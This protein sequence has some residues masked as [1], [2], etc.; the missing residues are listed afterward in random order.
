MKKKNVISAILVLALLFSLAPSAVAASGYKAETSAQNTANNNYTGAILTYNDYDNRGTMSPSGDVDWWKISFNA[1]GTANFWIGDILYP[2]DFDLYVYASNGTTLLGSSTTRGSADETVTFAVT[3]GTVYYCK[4]VTYPSTGTYT[5]TPYL[6]RAKVYPNLAVPLIGQEADWTCGAANMRMVLAY[7]GVSATEAAVISKAAAI[8]G[9][10]NGCQYQ[11]RLYEVLN[12]YPTGVTYKYTHF[13][14]ST[15][16]NYNE[17]IYKN[18]SNGKPV[19]ALIAYNYNI[20][21]CGNLHF[22]YTSGGHFVTITGYSGTSDNNIRIN[23]SA[24]YASVP[25]GSE[26]VTMP[27]ACLKEYT[28]GNSRTGDVTSIYWT[29][30]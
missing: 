12:S 14:S 10:S 11:N 6:F 4:I 19:I 22:N 21:A 25:C 26:Y 20:A 13:T 29:L 28:L 15:S 2:Y 5:D 27:I 8:T 7:Y 24:K 9:V 23:N 1:I 18:L 30:P 17:N 3:A 16:S